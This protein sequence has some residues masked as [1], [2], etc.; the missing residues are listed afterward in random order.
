MLASCLSENLESC[1]RATLL[2]PSRAIRHEEGL[3]SLA[4][5]TQM[6]FGHTDPMLVLPYGVQAAVDCDAKQ[7]AIIESGVTD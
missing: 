7:V 4:V 5:V 2:R 3:E 6:D 1:D